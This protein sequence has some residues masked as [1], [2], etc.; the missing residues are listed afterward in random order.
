[1]RERIRIVRGDITDATTDAIVNAANTE[2]M[3]G[4]GVAGA[5]R[6]KGGPI[7]QVDCDKIGPI[8]LG[9]AVVT[10][11][12]NL[13]AK[14]VI[15]AASMSLGGQ[16]TEASLRRAVRNSYLRA[17]EKQIKS[18]AFPAIGAGI[19]GFPIRQCA[20][21]MMDETIR[22]LQIHSVEKVEFHLFDATAYDAF[23]EAYEAI[24]D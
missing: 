8:K 1:M 5:I 15:H 23:Q 22:A 13:A 9:E 3:L 7:I 18:I 6:K 17:K 10:G 12:G 14:Y 19:A 2:L 20:E 4:G 16:A 21:I 11:A 24:G